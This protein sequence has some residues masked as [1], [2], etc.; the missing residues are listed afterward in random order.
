MKGMAIPRRGLLGAAF[1]SLWL[2]PS[3][4]AA[5]IAVAPSDTY[6]KIESAQAGD[7]VVIAPGTYAFRVH[8]TRA[9]TA[10]RPIVIRASGPLKS[11]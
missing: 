11:R 8:L 10:D 1:T 7:E 2:A 4:T 5:T 3:A 9:G 6:Q